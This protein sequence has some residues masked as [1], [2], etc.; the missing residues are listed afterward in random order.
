MTLYNVDFNLIFVELIDQ[1]VQDFK[2]KKKKKTYKI[3][4]FVNMNSKFL[5]TSN[6][7]LPSK[8]NL[9]LHYSVCVCV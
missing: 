3:K 2:K 8:C 1:D 5:L 6:Y 9:R 4:E 7:I